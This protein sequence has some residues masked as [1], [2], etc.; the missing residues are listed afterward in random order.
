[1]KKIQCMILLVLAG[2]MLSVL[3]PQRVSAA[4]ND[5]PRVIVTG[6]EA[7]NGGLTPGESSE[8]QFT[9]K[10]TSQEYTVYSVLITC[11]GASNILFAQYGS[12]NQAYVSSIDPGKEVT[13]SLTLSALDGL[14]ADTLA[15]NLGIDYIDDV[16]GKSTSNSTVVFPVKEDSLKVTRINIPQTAVVG[17]KTRIS[18]TFENNT[19]EDAYNSVMTI[20]GSGMDDTSVDMGTVLNQ[21]SKSQ[22]VYIVL[23]DL[24]E[25]EVSL[26]AGYQDGQGNEI[27]NSSQKYKIKV[28]EQEQSDLTN[29][30]S[31]NTTNIGNNVQISKK[32]G[33]LAGFVVCLLVVVFAYFRKR[34][35]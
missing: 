27:T 15:A 30:P 5:R 18:V 19:T 29:K 11:T 33:Y 12:S 13:V 6:Y 2:I 1:M 22:E 25:Q 8:V 31:G 16:N 26:E 35:Q 4:G 32:L 3:A 23:N 9:L 10:N 20:K 24:G 21:S 17:E 34:T 28:V 7:E 14:E